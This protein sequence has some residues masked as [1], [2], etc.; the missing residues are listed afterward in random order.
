M[1]NIENYEPIFLANIAK[2][3]NKISTKSKNTLKKKKT[4]HHDKGFIPEMQG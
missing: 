2:I 1:S 3:L 4:I